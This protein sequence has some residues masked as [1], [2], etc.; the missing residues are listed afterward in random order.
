MRMYYNTSRFAMEVYL[1]GT[2]WIRRSFLSFVTYEMNKRYKEEKFH[3]PGWKTGEYLSFWP[4][5]RKADKG[6]RMWRACAKQLH[7]KVYKTILAFSRSFFASIIASRR[8]TFLEHPLS[9]RFFPL[10]PW[11]NCEETVY[12]Y[13]I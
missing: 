13:A 11:L 10:L 4:A 6:K 8:T 3:R 5:K 1:Y 7:E 12:W 9:S 2:W